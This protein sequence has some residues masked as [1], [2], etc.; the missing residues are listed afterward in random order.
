MAAMRREGRLNMVVV[1]F[2]RGRPSMDDDAMTFAPS[3]SAVRRQ[4]VSYVVLRRTKYRLRTGLARLT[5]LK[6]DAAEEK[7]GA[8]RTQIIYSTKRPSSG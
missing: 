5:R 7:R 3:Q 2:M 4:M 6:K 1:F 8:G